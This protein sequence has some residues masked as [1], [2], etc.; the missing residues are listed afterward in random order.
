MISLSYS[1]RYK[2]FRFGGH[3]A[4]RSFG[5]AMVNCLR[6]AVSFFDSRR[7]RCTKRTARRLK[8]DVA[9]WQ[10][11]RLKMQNL[12]N[13]ATW[14]WR[15][16]SQRFQIIEKCTKFAHKKLETQG[17]HRLKTRTL[18]SHLHGLESVPDRTW[19]TDRQTDRIT[20]ANTRLAVGLYLLSRVKKLRRKQ[21]SPSLPPVTIVWLSDIN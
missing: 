4:C 2:Y 21:Y 13:E 12:S 10:L 8:L 6:I 16:K 20:I 14:N 11:G 18:L 1:G 15:T 9:Q 7:T 3:S 17:Y 5:I 19:Q